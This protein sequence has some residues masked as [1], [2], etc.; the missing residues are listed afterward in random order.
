MVTREA[1]ERA[2]EAANKTQI[3]KINIIEA[4]YFGGFQNGLLLL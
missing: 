1:S 4:N 3:Y 2:M